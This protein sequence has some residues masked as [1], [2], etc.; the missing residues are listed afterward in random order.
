MHP[1]LFSVMNSSSA[2][3]D[4]QGSTITDYLVPAHEPSTLYTQL[5]K[6]E[7]LLP[8]LSTRRVKLNRS[9]SKVTCTPASKQS[10]KE[11]KLCSRLNYLLSGRSVQIFRTVYFRRGA[12]QPQPRA[13]DRESSCEL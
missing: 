6:A 7:M 2:E 3:R 4:Q 9:E 10:E 11:L 13:S 12:G 1:T 8:M 5:F